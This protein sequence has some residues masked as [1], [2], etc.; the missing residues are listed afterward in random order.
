M[1]T[2]RGHVNE[3]PD[4][5]IQ[6]HILCSISPR[7]WQRTIFIPPL[8]VPNF[9]FPLPSNPLAAFPKDAQFPR[10]LEGFKSYILAS[11]TEKPASVSLLVDIKLSSHF[12][13]WSLLASSSAT[14]WE[15]EERHLTFLI[16]KD[17]IRH[18][19]K[20]KVWRGAGGVGET[21]EKKATIKM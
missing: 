6:L 5:G 17:F 7:N 10:L 21:I 14:A 9:Y 18:Y 12:F 20:Y 2:K 19:R 16:C 11:L 1:C 15:K 13:L 3:S 8:D 4:T